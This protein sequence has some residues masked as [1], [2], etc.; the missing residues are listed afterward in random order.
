MKIC[1]I[2]FNK[3]NWLKKIKILLLHNFNDKIKTTNY[4]LFFN[5]KAWY[6]PLILILMI[7]SLENWVW[8]YPILELEKILPTTDPGL[9]SSIF[10]L[11]VMLSN[12]LIFKG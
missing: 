6:P 11:Q 3:F 1:L 8:N 9:T 5:N 4:I 10:E 12:N 2:V 7:P